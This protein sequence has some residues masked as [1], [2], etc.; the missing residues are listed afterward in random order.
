MK[1]QVAA[2]LATLLLCLVPGMSG[3]AGAAPSTAI[4][5]HIDRKTAYVNGDAVTLDSAPVIPEGESSTYVPVRFI[6]ES[7]GAYIGWDG[8]ERKVTYL[9]G[10]KQIELWIGRKEARVG[11]KSVSL[12]A[13]PYVD[14]HDRT[15]VPVR[16]VSEQLGATVEWDATTK[17][18]TVKAPW[19][20]KVVTMQDN[21]FSPSYLEVPAG[22]RITWVNLDPVIHNVVTPDWYSE[23]FSMGKTFSRTLTQS[24]RMDYRCTLHPNMEAVIVVK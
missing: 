2:V 17:G 13:A 19:Y 12:T 1:R 21:S 6:G 3:A 11:G 10:D 16:F 9:T 18:V 7:L 22:T 8:T 20:G 4:T 24:G 15:L 23:T 14:E 5:L